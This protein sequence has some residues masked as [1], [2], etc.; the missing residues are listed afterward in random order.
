MYVVGHREDQQCSSLTLGNDFYLFIQ[1][2]PLD[3][4]HYL[5]FMCNIYTGQ[6][7]LS[8]PVVKGSGELWRAPTV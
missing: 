6:K 1:G 8:F 5:G 7:Q 2:A 3:S 4:H